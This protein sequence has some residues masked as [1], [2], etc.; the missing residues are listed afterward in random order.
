MKLVIDISKKWYE[1]A[2]KA[3]MSLDG[4]LPIYQA[5]KEGTPYEERPRGEWEEIY[6]DNMPRL[7]DCSECKKRNTWPSD[8]CPNCGLPMTEKAEEILLKRGGNQNE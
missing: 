1:R 6:F 7:W 3:N 8:F 4:A 2:C 5:I